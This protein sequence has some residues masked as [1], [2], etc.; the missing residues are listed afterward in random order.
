MVATVCKVH[1][2]I[3]KIIEYDAVFTV[4]EW[5]CPKDFGKIEFTRHIF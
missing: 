3:L 2:I 5:K 1:K 4:K